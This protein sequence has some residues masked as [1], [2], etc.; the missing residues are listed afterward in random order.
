MRKVLRS[1][2]AQKSVKRIIV[3]TIF[4][5]TLLI[6]C[7]IARFSA[8]ER[9]YLCD[10]E[11]GDDIYDIILFIGQ[12]NM[13]GSVRREIE[14]RYNHGQY[15]YPE[16]LSVLE[17]SS[18]TGIERSILENNGQMMNFVSIKQE[19]ETA[20]E[21]RYLTNS[22]RPI[23][24]TQQTTYGEN[25]VYKDGRLIEYKN[26]D[27]S[28]ISLAASSGTNMIPQFCQTYYKLTGHKVI[29]VSAAKRGIPI[30]A[31]LPQNDRRNKQS[32]CC[33]YEALRMKYEGALDL[34]Q[35]QNLYI[36]NKFY[37]IAQGESDISLGTTKRAY[38][39]MYKALH[40]KLKK[41]LGIQ[42][43]AIVETSSTTG[44]G[45]M[46]M[47]NVIHQAQEELIKENNDI[48]LGSS[49]F[50]DRFVPTKNDYK[51]C[52][53]EV[54]LGDDGKKLPYTEALRRSRYSTDPSCK[55]N[56]KYR[57]F[58]HFTSAALSHVGIDVATN[59]S[60]RAY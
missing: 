32:D 33:V 41:E 12:S 45:T 6:V 2:F 26:T 59:L 30:Q 35:K 47:I 1:F 11:K 13:V 55:A 51:N 25:L 15:T 50:Y 14:D 21:Y 5:F 37:V 54:T 29:A 7:I 49:Y 39:S 24:S 18:L 60:K 10:G 28:F 8:A 40:K 16:A 53:T 43:G 20:F 22:F 9:P 56:G 3:W 23:D 48:I 58:I 42:L 4:G 34:A 44:N 19:K 46:K 17:Y 38:K 27:Q 31:F 57:N 52:Y 36:G